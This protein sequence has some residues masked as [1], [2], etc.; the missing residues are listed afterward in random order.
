MLY[1]LG[2]GF[3]LSTESGTASGGDVIYTTE[4]GKK[5]P[6]TPSRPSRDEVPSAGPAPDPTRSPE[7]IPA[8]DPV[9]EPQREPATP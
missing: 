2:R 1:T 4:R 8:P 5:N 3:K 6:D 9:V 7:A